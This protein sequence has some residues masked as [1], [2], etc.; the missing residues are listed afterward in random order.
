MGKVKSEHA[1]SP[2][3][4]CPKKALISQ[5]A[6]VAHVQRKQQRARA[7]IKGATARCQY[8][9]GAYPAHGPFLRTEAQHT[10]RQYRTSRSARA[11]ADSSIA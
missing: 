10:L 5:R 6:F 11:Q 4:L 2:Y 7:G 8:S 1:R 3:S 9:V